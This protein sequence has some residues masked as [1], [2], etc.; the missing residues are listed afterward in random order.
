[1]N[2]CCHFLGPPSPVRLTLELWRPPNDPPG[3]PRNI[4]IISFRMIFALFIANALADNALS[5]STD[6]STFSSQN[7][8]VKC[9]ASDFSKVS[10][11]V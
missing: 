8:D 1:M 6:F 4:L 9:S 10:E 5:L 2:K 7:G 3:T 11:N